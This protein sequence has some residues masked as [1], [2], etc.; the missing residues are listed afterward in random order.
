MPTSDR[1]ICWGQGS[2]GREPTPCTKLR[3]WQHACVFTQFALKASR[4][5]LY[6]GRRGIFCSFWTLA[7]VSSNY[8]TVRLAVDFSRETGFLSIFH[9]PLHSFSPPPHCNSFVGCNLGINCL[10][11]PHSFSIPPHPEWNVCPDI[12]KFIGDVQVENVRVG[13]F[14]WPP[15]SVPPR[16]R[17]FLLIKYPSFLRLPSIPP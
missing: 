14:K 8:L 6:L 16:F 10:Q 9:H 3:T 12:A 1:E 4:V 15:F 17:F 11:L 13:F 5:G 7:V 2:W